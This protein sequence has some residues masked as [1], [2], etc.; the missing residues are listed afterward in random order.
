MEGLPGGIP[1]LL[2]SITSQV[3][4]ELRPLI[5]QV[6]FPPPSQDDQRKVRPKETDAKFAEKLN[7]HTA[8]LLERDVWMELGYTWDDFAGM[9]CPSSARPT[10][11]R[12]SAT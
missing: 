12:F 4:N 11:R 2:D 10:A 9:R 1:A 8:F 6:G 5:N 3:G 7:A